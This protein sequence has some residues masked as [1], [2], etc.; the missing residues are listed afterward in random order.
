V[1]ANGEWSMIGA[2]LGFPQPLLFSTWDPTTRTYRRLAQCVPVVTHRLQQ[3]YQDALRHFDQAYI[4]RSASVIQSRNLQTS[5]DHALP[6]A[7]QQPADLPQAME[8]DYQALLAAISISRESSGL[9]AEAMS[10]LPRFANTPGAALEA[11]GVP[12]NIIA[13]VEQ[14]REHLQR[15]AQ[16]QNRFRAGLLGATSE[17]VQPRVLNLAQPDRAPSTQA[18][19]QPSPSLQS[20]QVCLA[21]LPSSHHRKVA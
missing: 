15:A 6:Q 13:F 10:L 14:N 12:R 7:L 9:T 20:Q 18:M 3:L 19:A 21:C 1:T 17:N 11:N 4:G 8:S 16:D 5:S 2:T